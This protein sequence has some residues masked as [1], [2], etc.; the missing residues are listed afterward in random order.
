MPGKCHD[1]P[2]AA[3]PVE[4]DC[5][6]CG[7]DGCE[8]CKNGKVIVDG[9]PLELVPRPV[10]ALLDMAALYRRG[11][12]PVA[13]GALDQAQAFLDAVQFAWAEMALWRRRRR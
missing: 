9:C 10:W 4:I 7:G 11:L 12:P 5:P 8:E 3:L 2:T 1:K 6:T 13:G